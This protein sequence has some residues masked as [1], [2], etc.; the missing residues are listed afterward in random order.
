[1][2]EEGSR[3]R[4]PTDKPIMLAMGLFWLGRRGRLRCSVVLVEVVLDH[5]RRV[6]GRFRFPYVKEF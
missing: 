3:E 6:L 5:S 1:M 2:S 4:A